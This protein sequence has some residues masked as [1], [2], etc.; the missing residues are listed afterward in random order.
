MS[1][2]S[3]GRPV[4]HAVRALRCLFFVA[5]ALFATWGVHVPSVKAH[6]GLSEQSL[7]LAMF[8][9]GAGA[10]VALLFAGRV[11]ARRAPRS[12]VPLTAI[13]SVAAVGALLAPARYSW[14]LA[15]M[16][17][18]GM[19]AA[20]LDV[21]INDEATALERHAG[22][23]L[24]SGFHGM[25]SLGG[26]AGACAWG[27]LAPIGVS[28]AMHM[29][30]ASAALGVLALVASAFMLR[31]RRNA[32]PAGAPLS[33]PRGPLLLLG[34]LASLGFVGEGAMYDW[35]VLYLRQEL[36][37]TAGVASLGYASFSG[38]M[39]A[40][41]FGGD[42]ARARVPPVTLLRASG[43]L[44]ALGML[45]ALS[46]PH[47][48]GALA[49]FA[50]AGLGFANIVPVLFSVAGRFPGVPA[51]HGIAAVSSVGYF[52]LMAGPPLIG[53]IAQAHSLTA[54]L[55]VVVVFAAVVAL[56]SGRALGAH[57][58]RTD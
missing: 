7:A 31:E 30:A 33:I 9:A 16:L 49:G 18:Y 21:A 40:G 47:P 50:L 8:A 45:L 4:Q 1:S 24:M 27:V 51:A 2:L 48:A 37:T 55:L 46:V 56:F 34:I 6:Y 36:G 38:A 44:G 43:A 22:R 19:A 10:I 20:L 54:G 15:L 53:F 12:V 26:L 23:P 14:L 3:A 58:R 5:G 32:A 17:A 29:V 25:F 52:G 35:S 42:W 28:P 11:L 13:V 41:R 57:G 39:A